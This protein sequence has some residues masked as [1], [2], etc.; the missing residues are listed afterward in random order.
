MSKNK[1]CPQGVGRQFTPKM[2]TIWN[3]LLPHCNK[4]GFFT[5]QRREENVQRNTCQLLEKHPWQSATGWR[6]SFRQRNNR[7]NMSLTCKKI[8]DTV[9][10]A[11]PYFPSP[12]MKEQAVAG[13]SRLLKCT[14][15]QQH[16]NTILHEHLCD[17]LDR[18][19]WWV[20]VLGRCCHSDR[21]PPSCPLAG[22]AEPVGRAAPLGWPS[23]GSGWW[24]VCCR[25]K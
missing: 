21:R 11:T 24:C 12:N 7:R 2:G 20:Y 16:S 18:L 3:R 13:L 8:W 23:P 17:W 22:W 4:V 14:Y 6:F 9:Q 25:R 10:Q 5:S 15:Q 1:Q 19:T